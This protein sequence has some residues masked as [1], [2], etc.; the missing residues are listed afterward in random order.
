MLFFISGEHITGSLKAP[1]IGA[2]AVTKVIDLAFDVVYYSI[3]FG[4][5]WP[6]LKDTCTFLGIEIKSI[7]DL[8]FIGRKLRPRRSEKPT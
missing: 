8:P 2:L 6:L 3:V 7:L 4:F 1:L 5:G